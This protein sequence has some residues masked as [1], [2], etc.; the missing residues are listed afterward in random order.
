M[1]GDNVNRG[2]STFQVVTPNPEGLEDGQQLLVV[3]VVVE[4]SPI[5][6]PRVERNR[7]NFTRLRV[8]RQDSSES[9]VR[10]ISLDDDRTIRLPVEQD[11]SGSEGLLQVLEGGASLIGEEERGTLTGE[12]GQRNDDVGVVVDEATIEVSEAQERLNVLHVARFRPVLNDFDLSRR[13]RQT[14][15][16]KDI[17]KVFDGLA[18]ELALL[19]LGIEAMLAKTS[20]H[21]TNMHPVVLLAIGVHQDIIE[22]HNDVDVN[23]VCEDVVHEA[24]ESSR[25]VGESKRHNHPLK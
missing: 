14:T 5:E 3:D 1:V 25:C 15:R 12:A 18:M 16:G 10:G 13:H 4:F 24:L 21:L 9:I 19:R 11:R 8:D 23:H 2:S 20:Q 7:M 22:I 6:R 17:P